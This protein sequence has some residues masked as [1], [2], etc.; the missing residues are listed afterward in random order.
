MP[1]AAER[2][3][4]TEHQAREMGGVANFQWSP[5]VNGSYA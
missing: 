5:W 4:I 2:L 1:E 3:G